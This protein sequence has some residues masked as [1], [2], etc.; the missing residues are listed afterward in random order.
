MELISEEGVAQFETLE[1]TELPLSLFERVV[2]DSTWEV[3][4]VCLRAITY[5]LFAMFVRAR[6]ESL[7]TRHGVKV[8]V[9]AQASER[10]RK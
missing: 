5:E 7:P 9:T 3:K 4:L 8:N 2:S 10:S 1:G 6:N